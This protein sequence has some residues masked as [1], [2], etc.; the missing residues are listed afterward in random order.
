M[1][2]TKGR[3]KEKNRGGEERDECDK[4]TQD[5]KETKKNKT[6][7]KKKKTPESLTYSFR[8]G[9]DHFHECSSRR[10]LH[11]FFF[12]HLPGVQKLQPGQ[13]VQNKVPVRKKK[14]KNNNNNSALLYCCHERSP[15][16]LA[17]DKRDKQRI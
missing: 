2:R 5:F 11:H 3:I 17:V 4:S 9:F 1:H 14:Q 16:R 10:C 15:L 12:C 6:K 7:P 8:L 13:L